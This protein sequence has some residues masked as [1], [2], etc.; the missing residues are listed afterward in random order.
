[1]LSSV[2]KQGVVPV[3]DYD[4]CRA[5]DGYHDWLTPHPLPTHP[6]P[7]PLYTLPL[8]LLHPPTTTPTHPPL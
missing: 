8:N 2:L 1:M 6:H 7:L 3:M 5:L 4:M